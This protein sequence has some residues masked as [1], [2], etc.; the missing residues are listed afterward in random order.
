MPV[1]RIEVRAT[2]AGD[3]PTAAGVLHEIRQLGVNEVADV[4]ASRVFLLQGPADVLTPANLDRIAREVL[5]DPVTETFT[6]GDQTAS[7][8]E[9]GGGGDGGVQ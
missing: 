6:L 2:Q 1:V 5:I 7:S 4:R 9:P 8:D 3:D